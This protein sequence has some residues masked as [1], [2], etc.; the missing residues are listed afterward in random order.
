MRLRGLPNPGG[1]EVE[2]VGG[3]PVLPGSLLDGVVAE[4]GTLLRRGEGGNVERPELDLRVMIGRAVDA[5]VSID[6]VLASWRG[7]VGACVAELPAIIDRKTAQANRARGPLPRPLVLLVD[8]SGFADLGAGVG[9]LFFEGTL[10][11]LSA[12]LGGL[13]LEVF[14]ALVVGISNLR[15]NRFTGVVHRREGLGEG[16]SRQLAVAEGALLGDPQG[17][18]GPGAARALMTERLRQKGLA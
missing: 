6:E 17:A 5:S 11:E 16:E 14:D 15:T 13:D 7:Q 4:A 10:R 1:L 9:P 18:S 2:T 3:R 8:M 12:R